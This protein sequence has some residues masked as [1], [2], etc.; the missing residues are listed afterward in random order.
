MNFDPN[1]ELMA[2]E[3][4]SMDAV[5]AALPELG[6]SKSY[7]W[8]VRAAVNRARK[9]YGRPLAHIPACVQTFEESWAGNRGYAR[10]GFRTED[11]FRSWCSTMRGVLARHEQY[12]MTGGWQ[13]V[14]G[15][16]ASSR[17]AEFVK[18]EAHALGLVSSRAFMP[19]STL[20]SVA[21][22]DGIA[23]ASADEP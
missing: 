8:T 19:F 11:Q 2:N 14:I 15:D 17:V 12:R 20:I 6:Y 13:R 22:E 5:A 9:A 1:P 3:A 18:D 16:G 21:R 23:L 4:T 7:F 10:F